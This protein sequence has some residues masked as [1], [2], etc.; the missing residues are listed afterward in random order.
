MLRTPPSRRLA[1]TAARA[2]PTA[3]TVVVADAH[4]LVREALREL[5]EHQGDF[6]VVGE[7]ADGPTVVALARTLRPSVVLLDLRL[8]R[9]AASDV[10]LEL[11]QAAPDVRVMVVAADGSDEDVVEALHR[12]ARGV[13]MKHGP[14]EQLFEGIRMVARGDYWVH[15]DR[16][17]GLVALLQRGARRRPDREPGFGF[18]VRE[19]QLVAAVVDGCTNSDIAARLKIS[20]KTVKHHLTKIFAKVGVSNRIE[21]AMFAVQHQFRNGGFP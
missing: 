16:V 3:I 13:V 8:A 18:T 4:A 6:E 2:R 14:A 19:L 15:R 7:A 12:G 17:G 20:Q 10:L 9:G 1:T 11:S 5:L 21:L